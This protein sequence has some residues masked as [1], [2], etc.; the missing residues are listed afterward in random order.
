MIF[1]IIS[2]T[3]NNINNNTYLEMLGFIKI[4]VYSKQSD[5]NNIFNIFDHRNFLQSS[6]KV[7]QDVE[8]R[9][10]ITKLNIKDDQPKNFAKSYSSF[11]RRWSSL[12]LNIDIFI[13]KVSWSSK[14]RRMVY[15]PFLNELEHV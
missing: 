15:Y 11:R 12:T 9:S 7:K 10:F 6:K 1:L 14:L 4:P 13:L 5:K 2:T 8:A 3:L